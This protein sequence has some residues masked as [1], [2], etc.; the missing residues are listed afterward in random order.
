MDII[1]Y[2]HHRPITSHQNAVT[3]GNFD[4]VHLGHQ[5]L[6]KQVVQQAQ[7]TGGQSIVVTMKPL[8]LQFFK[9]KP[10]VDIITPFKQKAQLLRDLGVDV[11]CVLNF[12]AH[13]ATMS[14]NDF[15]E[16]LLFKGLKPAYVLVGDDFRFGAGRTGNAD[17]LEQR[18]EAANC[19]FGQ[20]PSVMV[21]GQRVSS[22]LIR[23]ALHEGDFDTVTR[24]L[25]RPFA[26]AGRVAH[27]QKLGRTLGFPTLNI[28]IK[29]GGNALHGVYVVRVLIQGSWHQAVASIG[30]K[31]TVGQHAKKLEVHVFDF[32]REIYGEYVEVLFYQKLRNEVE[33]DGLAALKAAIAKDAADARQY[34]EENK[35]D[36]V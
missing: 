12:N 5:A 33:F 10:A 24:F 19:V 26:M 35:G 13:L 30:H 23:A 28:H 18:C 2:P 3:I 32:N 20:H 7:Q 1:R 6:I 22:S 34:F 4:G 15:V 31:P 25:G 27:G 8:P 36:L 17:M 14:A 9:G 29:S 11:M 16:Q 21:A